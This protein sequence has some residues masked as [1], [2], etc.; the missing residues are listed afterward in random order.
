VAISQDKKDVDARIYQYTTAADSCMWQFDT[1]KSKIYLDSASLYIKNV[2]NPLLHGFYHQIWGNFYTFERNDPLAHENYY[3]AIKWYEKT[4]QYD[5]I[6]P[7]YYQLAFTYYQKQDTAMLAKMNYQIKLISSKYE[8]NIAVLDRLGIAALYYHGL[9]TKDK[10]NTACLDSVVSCEM[11]FVN[12]Y[13]SDST[14]YDQR[15]DVAF[16]YMLLALC[17]TNSHKYQPDSIGRYLEKAKQR[18]NP[19]DMAMM[20]NLCYIN[21]EIA[22]AKNNFTD[23][24]YYFNRVLT[25]MKNWT[26]ND[27][28]SLYIDVY[29]RLSEISEQKQDYKAALEYEREKSAWENKIF[30]IDTSKIIADLNEKY[31]VKKKDTEIEHLHERTRLYLGIIALALLVFFFSVRWVLLRKKITDSQLQLEKIRKEKLEAEVRLKDERLKKAELE[32]YETLLD[33]Y[34][35]N[36][37][38]SEADNTLM[39]LKNEQKKLNGDL[40][41]YAERLTQ[42]EQ[43]KFVSAIE[44]PY[45]NN[46]ANDVYTLISKR[47]NDSNIK[48]IYYEL[49]KELKNNFFMNL[50]KA[51]HGDLSV[52]NIKYCIGF[53]TG[54]S[55]KDIAECFSVELH[56]V[57]KVRHRLKSKLNLDK[58]EDIDFNLFLRQ[59]N[60]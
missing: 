6:T 53:A 21:G 14:L 17:M 8:N 33:L 37:Q 11:Q 22:L 34:F 2:G 10:K 9:Y 16:N 27:N 36:R 32:K 38:I 48:D 49:L 18:I 25:V 15:G 31:E 29:S 41:K 60:N 40:Q 47:V 39:E 30:D 45:F 5:R 19:L 57:H 58:N 56:T 13:E 52:I 59:L 26:E 4:K 1:N 3:K 46:I 23:A 42:Y 55:T 43:M 50:I 28:Q 24:E 44:D 51:F 35:K 7:L 20:V 54:M 12:H